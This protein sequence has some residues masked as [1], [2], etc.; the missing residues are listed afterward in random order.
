MSKKINGYSPLG[1]SPYSTRANSLDRASIQSAS[2]EKAAKARPSGD[3]RDRD[4]STAGNAGDLSSAERRM[5][6]RTFPEDPD[7][8]LRL[9]G[10]NRDAQTIN[11]GAVGNQLDVQG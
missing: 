11:P 3:V 9:Y 5:I 10:P 8:S 7:L 6:R 4:P 1:Y 2:V